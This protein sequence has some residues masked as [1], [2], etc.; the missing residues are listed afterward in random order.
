[1]KSSFSIVVVAGA[2]LTA[3]FGVGSA[4]AQ[5]YPLT[6]RGG[7]TLSITC[8]GGNGVLIRFQPGPGAVT[9]GL[10]PGQATWS[11]RALRPGEPTVIWDDAGSAARYV[12]QLVHPSQYVILQVFNDGQGHM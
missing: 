7:G 2:L 8:D 6:C 3:T 1:M 12:G 5:S 10:A 11:D 4:Q 9:Q